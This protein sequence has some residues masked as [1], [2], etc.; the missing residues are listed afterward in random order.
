M[1]SILLR[2]WCRNAAAQYTAHTLKLAYM[3]HTWVFNAYTGAGQ[4]DGTIDHEERS[5][6]R[7]PG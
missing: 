6:T 4:A 7:G 1:V 3:Q 5:L 2:L